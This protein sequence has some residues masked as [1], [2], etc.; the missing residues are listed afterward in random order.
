MSSDADENQSK[1]RCSI[2]EIEPFK[3][4]S[5]SRIDKEFT[6]ITKHERIDNMNKLVT[7]LAE[8]NQA[9]FRGKELN[10]EDN[11]TFD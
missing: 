8:K 11:I 7:D 5:T 6:Q 3:K 1:V 9:Y 10:F 4:Y 2:E